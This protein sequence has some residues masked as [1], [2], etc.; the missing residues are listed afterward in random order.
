[1]LEPQRAKGKL[2]I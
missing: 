1:M 2:N